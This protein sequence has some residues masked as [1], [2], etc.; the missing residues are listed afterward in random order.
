VDDNAFINSEYKINLASRTG[1]QHTAWYQGLWNISAGQYFR[2]FHP[3]IH[4]LGHET[5]NL[6]PS[7]P[8][9][10]ELGKLDPARAQF[11]D[12]L[13]RR[14][15]FRESDAVKWFAAMDYGYTHPTVVLLG[16]CDHEDNLHIVDE[17][18]ERFW[19][20]QRHA[21]A[22]KAMLARHRIYLSQ[23]HLRESIRA[24]YPD[25]CR[26]QDI[27]WHQ[28]LQ[29]MLSCFVAG[30]DVFST[31]S[32]GDS[33][34][35]QYRRLGLTLHPAS[36]D[37]A[38]GWSAIAQPLGDPP[39]GILPSLFI[40]K[41]CR[42]LI[43]CLPL[44]QHDPDR[45]GDVLKANINEEGAGGDDPADALRYLVAYR[46]PEIHIRKLTGW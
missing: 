21:Q 6:P 12:D 24:Q 13:A 33:I 14:R 27:L 22:I 20:P 38:S 9:P 8:D 18:V 31:E 41:R 23:D 45:P 5:S 43:E 26:E 7:S 1:W 16:C 17:H 29:R 28:G 30:K 36:T 32:N 46:P 4:V 42:H 2:N 11:L 35:N 19:I 44:L 40:H 34:A 10:A 3:A 39:V 25:Y 15:R 37:R